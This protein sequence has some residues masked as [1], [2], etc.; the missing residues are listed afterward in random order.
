MAKGERQKLKLLA[1]LDILRQKSDEEHPLTM[2]QIIDLLARQG[3]SAERKSLYDDMEALRTFGYDVIS[4]K[5]KQTG[6]YLGER[7]FSLPEL[8]I[9]AGAVESSRFITKKKSEELIRKLSEDMGEYGART[10]KRQLHISN[11][12]KSMNESIYYLV[13]DIHGAIAAGKRIRFRYF[14]INEKKEKVY[15]REGAFYE[16]SPFA[17]TWADE[18]YYLV[19]Y[20]A[21]AAALRHFRVDKMT[22]LTVT[23]LAREGTEIFEKC[24]IAAYSQ[25]VFGM[26]GGERE[27]VTLRVANRLAGV[28]LDRFGTDA[29]LSP[30]GDGFFLVHVRVAVS[31]TFFGWVFGFGEE[32][33]IV[34]PASVREDFYARIKRT[35]ALYQ[36]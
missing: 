35:S 3:I 17:L 34:S 32:M 16:V 14:F 11:R 33:Q 7:Q 30:S 29:L 31:P 24:D 15:R 13:D 26:F 36:S 8:K 4:V 25:S 10:L 28:I 12:V 27:A 6:Y 18:N 21:T 5:S 20:D 2:A 22:E 9:L 19:A 23:E 1:L